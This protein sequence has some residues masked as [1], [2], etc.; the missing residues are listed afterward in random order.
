M[1]YKKK[2]KIMDSITQRFR[3]GTEF[4]S[5]E[6]GNHPNFHII[7]GDFGNSANKI[8]GPH[9]MARFPGFAIQLGQFAEVH[10]LPSTIRVEDLDSGEMWL[11]GAQAQNGLSPDDKTISE[12]EQYSRY[13]WHSRMF[14]IL[15][16]ASIGS[17]IRDKGDMAKHILLQT[18]LPDDEMREDRAEFR[19]VLAGRYHFRL[20]LGD[21]DFREFN[22]E[23]E[24]K[25]IY[26]MEQ[27]RATLFSACMDS[28]MNATPDRERIMTKNTMVLDGG[29][30]TLNVY[31]FKAGVLQ[32]GL[33]YRNLGMARILHETS[34]RFSSQYGVR[35]PVPA[36]QSSLE[37]GTIRV[38]LKGGRGS[39]EQP[40]GDILEA[41][42]KNICSE[43]LDSIDRAFGFMHYDN[44]ILGGGTCA[45]WE[46]QIRE[47][48]RDYEGLQVISAG[49]NES[50]DPVFTNS[51]GLFEYR[52]LKTYSK[53]G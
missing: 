40:F 28:A 50:V 17:T 47:E 21:G 12:E 29:F 23:I 53:E 7:G 31:P 32:K 2:E 41:A 46:D 37:K 18:A 6:N 30:G 9:G 34:E 24:K 39:K 42:S 19:D 43:A 20:S 26:V 3:I 22:F 13:R 49:R 33:T 5:H 36:M 35:V 16:M 44:I 10:P 14:R 48:L 45:A 4:I 11:V 52:Y 25:N 51:R 8:W 27:A 15:V 38:R 1:K